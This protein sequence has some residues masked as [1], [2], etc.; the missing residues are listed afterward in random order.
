MSIQR[1]K[2]K[3]NYLNNYI[4]IFQAMRASEYFQTDNNKKIDILHDKKRII[5]IHILITYLVKI[6]QSLKKNGHSM[7]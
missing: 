1:K 5:I 6:L 3:K 7:E 4:K 2:I